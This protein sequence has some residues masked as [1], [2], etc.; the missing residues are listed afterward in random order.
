MD[1]EKLRLLRWNI[2]C[3]TLGLLGRFGEPK[4]N[5]GTPSVSRGSGRSNTPAMKK[6]RIERKKKL[7]IKKASQRRNR[8]G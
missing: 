8:A 6:H 4:S 2:A 5:F 1:T 3:S 7:K